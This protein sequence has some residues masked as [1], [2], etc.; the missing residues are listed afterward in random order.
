MNMLPAVDGYDGFPTE[1]VVG[2]RDFASE[3]WGED[4]NPIDQNYN[5]TRLDRVG[6]SRQE[7][8]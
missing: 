3:N 5:G 7:R 4:G 8:N 2:G 1:V 6:I